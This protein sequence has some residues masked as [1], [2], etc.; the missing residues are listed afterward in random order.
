MKH[1]SNKQ[2]LKKK[3]KPFQNQY[4]LDKN[5]FSLIVENLTSPLW[6]WASYQC[7]EGI[8]F[9]LKI[10]MGKLLTVAAVNELVKG[11][12]ELGMMCFFFSLDDFTIIFG[13]YKRTKAVNKISSEII[14]WNKFVYNTKNTHDWVP[15]IH[16]ICNMTNSHITLHCAFK[17]L[18]RTTTKINIKLSNK[19]NKK[20]TNRSKKSNKNWQIDNDFW[21]E[22]K[23]KQV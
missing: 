18:W 16:T 21:G 14:M 8:I 4:K 23:P 17:T 22:G 12:S 15:F 2:L 20:S 11:I 13:G 1:K 5:I 6:Q 3:L 7:F 9:S 19:L 10:L